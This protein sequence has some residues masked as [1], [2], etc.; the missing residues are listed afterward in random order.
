M[1]DHFETFARE[2]ARFRELLDKMQAQSREIGHDLDWMAG[3]ILARI[4]RD[5]ASSG[6]AASTPWPDRRD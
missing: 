2:S 3:V 6:D 4:E 1:T 5:S